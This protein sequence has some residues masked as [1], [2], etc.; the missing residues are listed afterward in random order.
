M[1]IKKKMN[2]KKLFHFI[3]FSNGTIGYLLK[4]VREQGKQSE[5]EMKRL[6]SSAS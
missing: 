4:L 2:L 3:Y 6:A 5:E 1:V